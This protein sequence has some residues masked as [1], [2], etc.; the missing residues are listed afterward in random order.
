MQKRKLRQKIRFVRTLLFA[1][2]SNLAPKELKH[3]REVGDSGLQE[4]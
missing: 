4:E 2:D 1:S 3:K